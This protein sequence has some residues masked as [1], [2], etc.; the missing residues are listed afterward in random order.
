MQTP[1]AATNESTGFIG[2][3][4]VIEDIFTIKGRGTVVTGSANGTV[5]VGDNIIIERQN[6]EN[7]ESVVTG[8]EA[9]R[10]MLDEAHDGDNVGLLLRGIDRTQIQRGDVIRK[11]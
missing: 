6:D 4:M 8:I 11:I 5:R 7:L 3:G 2:G 9:F 1:Q 10:K